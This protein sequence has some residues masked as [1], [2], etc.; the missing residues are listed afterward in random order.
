MTI[1][2][3][4]RGQQR[5]FKKASKFHFRQ[6]ASRRRSWRTC[7][8]EGKIFTPLWTIFTPPWMRKH[9]NNASNWVEKQIIR[10]NPILNVNKILFFL[11]PNCTQ[12]VKACCHDVVKTVV[13]ISTVHTQFSSL[14]FHLG[15]PS[16]PGGKVTIHGLGLRGSRG[17]QG[18]W[19]SR[20]S[21]GSQGSGAPRKIMSW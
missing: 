7:W 17:S 6:K 18:S 9:N 15:K 20:G 13:Q 8:R 16:G 19:G 1:N 3:G 4:L 2:T 14:D 12:K 11:N 10:Q 21:R 5:Y